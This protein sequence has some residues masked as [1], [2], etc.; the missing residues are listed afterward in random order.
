[1]V[2]YCTY[3]TTVNSTTEPISGGA[4]HQLECGL[5]SLLT[6]FKQRNGK[7][8]KNI[9]VYRDGVSDSQF[10]DVL[11]SELPALRAAVSD[12]TE[13]SLIKITI[14]VCQKRHHTRFVYQN[15][16]TESGYQN[17]CTGLCIDASNFGTTGHWD[18]NKVDVNT[19][20]GCIVSPYLNEFYLSSHLAVLGTSKP[21]KYILLCDEIGFTMPELELLTYW[22]TYMYS[23]CSR[24]VSYA[25]PAYYAHL[26][27]K[28]G[29]CLLKAGCSPAELTKMSEN[30]LDKNPSLYFI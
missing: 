24:S 18:T 15:E 21:T 23:R 12:H 14:V 3:L 11:V 10:E 8:P 28:R 5:T 25:T 17:P 6:T 26:A 20:T 22:L 7:L 9:I 1:M 16:S 30:W 13:E 4:Q 27:A 19:N 29:Q 2:Q